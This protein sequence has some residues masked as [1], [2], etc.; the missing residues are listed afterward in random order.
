MLWFF[1]GSPSKVNF[2]DEASLYF[3]LAYDGSNCLLTKLTAMI[4]RVGGRD[5][6]AEC[7]TSHIKRRKRSARVRAF[8]LVWFRNSSFT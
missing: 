2:V 8:R 5:C 4:S 6:A 3:D 1:D 7:E